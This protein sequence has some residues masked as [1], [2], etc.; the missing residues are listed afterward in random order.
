M[1]LA[2][3][4]EASCPPDGA[5]LRVVACGICGTDMRAFY[6]GDRRI[7]P[8]WILGHEIT[9]E[10]VE[11][12][13]EAEGLEA[14]PGDVVHVISTLH[15]GKCGLCRG[16]NEHLCPNGGL[17]GFDYA[18]AYAELV[19]V[20]QVALKNVYR[21]PEDLDPVHSTF[22]DPLSDAICGHKDLEV[23]P[24]QTV[25]VV[26]AGPVGT[27][28]VALA[29]AEGADEVHLLEREARR[30]ELAEAVLGNGQVTYVDV[31]E[32]DPVEYVRSVTEDGADRV[33]VANSSP[34]AQEQSLDMAA[35]RGRVLF[36]GGLPKG[37]TTIDFPSNVLHYR[38]VAVLGSYASRR[39]DQ[40]K[41]LEM[42]AAN[43][44]GIRGVVNDVVPL[45][46]TPAAFPRLKAGEA[47]KLVVTP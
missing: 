29:L 17:M 41:A 25:V 27:A 32:R 44:H 16:G 4:P 35:P 10:I 36:F 1:E 34:Q 26:G 38:E 11:V 15:C 2:D 31:S 24:G 33:I 47:L 8:G 23:G 7:G 13:P 30:L 45:E 21:L 46:E 20:P 37:T 28:H 39:A 19:A 12:G 6:N 9:G 40:V 22:A 18:G 3:V 5:L 14:A 43:T 42:L